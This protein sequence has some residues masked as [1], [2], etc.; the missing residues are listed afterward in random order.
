MNTSLLYSACRLQ[1]VISAF[2]LFCFVNTNAQRL[3][4]H[5]IKDFSNIEIANKPW[6]V[7]G[8]IDLDQ[9]VKK[10]VFRIHFDW[11]RHRKKDLITNHNYRRMSGGISALYSFDVIEKLT[12]RCGVEVNYTNVRHSYIIDTD[13]I[14]K[15]DITWLQTASFIGVGLHVALNY[16]L[17]P[18]FNAV[19]NFVPVYLIPVSSK[20]YITTIDP[21]Y[22]KGFWLFPIQLGLSY[23]LFKP[24]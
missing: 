3:E 6:G 16:E 18:R 19:L 1:I 23:K 21:L 12:F 15:K 11:A 2:L 20:S 8:A 24:D 4:V 5:G 14:N 17:T 9:L 13:T 22:K 10:T 7:G